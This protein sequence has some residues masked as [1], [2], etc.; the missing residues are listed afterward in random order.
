MGWFMRYKHYLE[1]LFAPRHI[2][3]VGASERPG[4]LGQTVFSNLMVGKLASNNED[5]QLSPVN[6]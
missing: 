5:L 6:P 3:V 2:A 4:S 1:P